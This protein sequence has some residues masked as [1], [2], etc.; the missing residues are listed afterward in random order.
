MLAGQVGVADHVH[1]GDRVQ[2]G[3][4]PAWP[5]DV[6]AGERMLGSPARPEGE[7][8]RI[9]LSLDRL[10]GLCRDVRRIKQQLGM[11]DEE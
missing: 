7:E 11:P 9:L 4:R 1:I 3:A 6:P 8:K 10:P 5:A 2:I